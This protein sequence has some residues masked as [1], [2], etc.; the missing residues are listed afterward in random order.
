MSNPFTRLTPRSRVNFLAALAV[1]SAA[2]ALA[3]DLTGIWQ[4]TVKNP[5]TKEEL[6]TVIKIASSKGNPILGSF[7]SIDQTFLVFPATITV[8]GSTVKMNIPGIAATYE[9]KLSPDGSKMTG[10]VKGFSV[11]T[12]WNMAR[13]SEAD[14]W[15]IPKPPTPPRPM[16]ADADPAFE[17]ATIKPSNPDSRQG[18]LRVQDSNVAIQYVTFGELFRQVYDIHP[19]QVIGLPS[20]TSS[21]R[22]D[23][24]G[25]PDVPGQPNT[26]QVKVMVRKLLASRF[27]LAFHKEQRELPVFSLNLAKGGAKI[28]VNKEKS[29]NT[30]IIFRGPG[31]FLLNN[32]NMDEFAR[33]LQNSAVDRPVVN[34]SGL[35]GKYTFAL[36]W[37]PD[38]ALAAL[39][40]PNPLATPD[41]AD[42][43]PDLFTAIQQQLGLKLDATRLRVDVMVI[44]KIEKPSAN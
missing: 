18:G 22:F 21:E 17:V 9:G 7:Y 24:A 4:G 13:V 15:A 30:G 14:A 33:M 23:I 16:A 5:D 20:W 27:Q 34:Q 36:V 28:A 41:R 11:P 1:V 29:E 2:G 19:N 31:S 3:Q 32:L 38:N 43:P 6:R 44:D 25:K 8:Q 35:A 42:I 39:P 37:T 10:T 26:D 12:P 40:N